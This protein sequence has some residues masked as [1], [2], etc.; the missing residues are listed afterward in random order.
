MTSEQIVEFTSKH[1]YGTWRYQKGWK[2]LHIVDAEGCYFTDASGKKYLDFSSQLM[3]S[4]LGHK[5]KAVIKSIAEQAE[6][7]SFIAPGFTTDVRAEL[8]KLL[9]EVLPA[10]L[11]KFY[12]STSGT[13]ANEA[14]IKIARMYTGKYKIISRYNSYH[15]STAAS[16]AA[17]GDPRRWA[18]EPAGKIDG[19]IF[20]PECNC[21]R[22]PLGHNYPDCNIVCAD[23]I[24]HIIKNE[25]NVAA[26]MIEPVV[27]T[28]GVLVPPKEYLPKLRKICDDNNVILIADEVMSGWGRT[29][30]WFAVDNWGIKPDI[31]T[32]AKGITS[33]YVPLGLTATTMKIADFFDNHYFAHGHT[34]EAHP[35][36]LAPAIA[37][38][39]E[40][41]RLGLIKQAA[42]K[43]IY[44]KEKL[45]ELKTKHPSIG[46]VRGIGLFWAVELVK[47]KE[48]KLPFN[49]KE[50]KI[51]GS[52]LMVDKVTSEMM[53]HGVYMQGW[54]SHFVIAPPLIIFEDQID[55]AIEVLD[56]A[57]TIVDSELS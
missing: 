13:E 17:T 6:K 7:L 56:S 30:Q 40:F 23:Y 43:G 24:E 44:L 55:I 48:S 51:K 53:K 36:T 37:A 39:N 22:C 1:T 35:L 27:G 46:D 18:V 54:I 2:P 33:A 52:Q 28:N 10:G 3:C 4:N 25:G 41:K 57:L 12:F 47:N 5:N 45:E 14:A 20:A 29:G 16:I 9:L 8:S 19:V 11:E 15:G 42:E 32:T 26:V 49:T 21:Y 34:Y 38:I 50:D 31:L